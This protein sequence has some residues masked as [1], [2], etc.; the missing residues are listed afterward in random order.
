MRRVVKP[1]DQCPSLWGGILIKDHHWSACPTHWGSTSPPPQQVFVHRFAF[2]MFVVCLG[3]SVQCQCDFWVSAPSSPPFPIPS[4]TLIFLLNRSDT[5]PFCPKDW[6]HR[7]ETPRGAKMGNNQKNTSVPLLLFGSPPHLSSSFRLFLSLFNAMTQIGEVLTREGRDCW[8]ISCI[9][10]RRGEENG[11]SGTDHDQWWGCGETSG[12]GQIDRQRQWL[13][14]TR[15]AKKGARRSMFEL[16]MRIYTRVRP[17]T[18]F[19]NV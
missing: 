1:K 15:K 17:R 10:E 18:V 19:Q 13:N 11:Q 3:K 16:V 5:I 8:A 4:Q 6:N 9:E 12:I 7:L 2:Q 14:G